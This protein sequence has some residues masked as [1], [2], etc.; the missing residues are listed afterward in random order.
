MSIQLPCAAVSVQ[1]LVYTAF[2]SVCQSAYQK[3]NSAHKLACIAS[4]VLLSYG[5]L[6][7]CESYDP[8]RVPPCQCSVPMYTAFFARYAYLGISKHQLHLQAC[9]C[10]APG[11]CSATACYT[12]ESCRSRCRVQLCQCSAHVCT[13]FC[14]V[15]QSAYQSIHYACKLVL[16]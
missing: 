14:S 6:R 7:G 2:S 13:A 3:I 15:C 9:A 16:A 4:G 11:V 8:S 10:I 12:D 1:C 5:M